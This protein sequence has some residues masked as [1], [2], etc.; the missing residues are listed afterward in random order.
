MSTITL[1]VTNG[2]APQG[3]VG[4]SRIRMLNS[5]ALRGL[6]GMYDRRS[7]LFCY[8]SKRGDAG[9]ESE[10][11]SHRYSVMA[12]LGLLRA[13]SALIVDALDARTIFES[14]IEDLQWVTNVG[15]LGL[16]LWLCSLIAPERYAKVWE[17][18]HA[19]NAFSHHRGPSADRSM[20]IAWFLAGLSHAKDSGISESLLLKHHAFQCF[21][22]LIKLQG[23]N[24]VF[25]HRMAGRF[26]GS[27]RG[28]LGSFADQVYPIYALA[29]FGQAF[30]SD[31]ALRM[32]SRCADTICHAQGSEGQWWWHYSSRQG[33]VVGRYPVYSVHQDGMAPMALLALGRATG[34]DYS[35]W[36]FK[37]LEWIWG[38]NELRKDLCED[39]LGVIWRNIYPRTMQRH[40]NEAACL[41]GLGDGSGLPRGLRILRECRP[42]HLGWLL[43]AFGEYGFAQPVPRPQ[44]QANL[45]ATA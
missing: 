32:A 13:R 19:G 40:L 16:L 41:L 38:N 26:A 14:L 36:I 2:F 4:V 6:I 1:N 25:G 44:G 11:V 24:G 39:S 43:Y 34:K 45:Y 21:D 9:V 3:S 20:E 35:P 42:Y 7:R 28:T 22:L 27:L 18:A 10:G 5:L 29:I 30:G 31:A 8:K 23:R 17:R 15:D 33:R 37:G 12:L